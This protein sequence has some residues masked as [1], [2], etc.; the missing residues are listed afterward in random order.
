MSQLIKEDKISEYNHV[1]TLHNL[2]QIIKINIFL[3]SIKKEDYTK[4][5][6]DFL[7]I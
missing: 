7:P 6:C 2:Y 4:T 3:D 1:L 5:V